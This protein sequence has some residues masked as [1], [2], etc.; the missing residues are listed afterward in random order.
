MSARRPARIPTSTTLPDDV[1]GGHA[2]RWTD[3]ERVIV[4]SDAVFAIVITLLVLDL[5]P[6][7]VA[8]GQ[9]LSGLLA[10][11]PTYLAY[12]ASYLVVGVVWMNH[13]AVFPHLRRM[14]PGLAW[15][16][17]AV[18]FTIGLLPF[19]TAVVTQALGAGN[20]ADEQTAVGLYALITVAISLSWVGFFHYLSRHPALLRHDA[21][22]AFFARER[23]RAGIGAVLYAAAGVLGALMTPGLAL[24]MF[25]LLPPFFALTSEGLPRRRGSRR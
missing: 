1:E 15:S 2:S 25:V 5:T 17:L 4:F 21:D 12:L 6:P 8:P 16:N 20:R 10:Q 9:L 13:R 24:A 11:W 3:P 22:E 19:P 7:D 18:L 14:D 23:G